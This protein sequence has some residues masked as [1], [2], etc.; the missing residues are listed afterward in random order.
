MNQLELF[1]VE[2]PTSAAWQRLD[3]AG[4]N[5]RYCRA[6]LDARDRHCYFTEVLETTP[7][8]QDEIV[9]FGRKLFVPRL[10]S[11]HGESDTGYTYS[12]IALEPRPWTP[13]LSA[14]KARVECSLETRF[15]SVLVNLYRDGRDSVAWHADDEP[16]LGP[17]P[18]IASLSLGAT[19]RF[20]LRNQADATLKHALDLHDGS[21]L[22]MAGATQHEWMH[23]IPKTK[24]E[25]GPRL[26]LTFRTVVK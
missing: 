6:F 12:N 23:Q 7:L 21:L 15:N 2:A 14:L 1:G 22:T 25:V 24:R 16:E 18:F 20:Q 17:A 13:A 4:A 10:A 26:N 3:L 5:I 9:M 8:T 19:R 11:W